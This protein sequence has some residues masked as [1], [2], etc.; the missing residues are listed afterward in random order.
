MKCFNQKWWFMSEKVRSWTTSNVNSNDLLLQQH[1]TL[2][3]ILHFLTW[4]DSYSLFRRAPA[5]L[6]VFWNKVWLGLIFNTWPCRGP[7]LVPCSDA[8]KV[9]GYVSNVS[10]LLQFDAIQFNLINSIQSI[11]LHS[12]WYSICSYY[13]LLVRSENWCI[14]LIK[15]IMC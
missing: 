2:L 10:L 4:S 3:Y 15:G 12:I 1:F 6:M 9:S 11:R 7:L 13:L 5:L 14:Q 8:W